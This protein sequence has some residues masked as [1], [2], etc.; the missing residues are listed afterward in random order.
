MNKSN[1]KILSEYDGLLV[2]HQASLITGRP[3]FKQLFDIYVTF[4]FAC[5][6]ELCQLFISCFYCVI[7]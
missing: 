2:D 5:Y 1:I 6:V 3:D 4:S 7:Y